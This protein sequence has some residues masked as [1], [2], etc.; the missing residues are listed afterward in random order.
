M[1][2]N[3]KTLTV[4]DHAR[5]RQ[6]MYLHCDLEHAFWELFNGWTMLMDF[7]CAGI[8]WDHSANIMLVVRRTKFLLGLGAFCSNCSEGLF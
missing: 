4:M 7:V 3:N 5:L 8:S 2:E 1:E 6:K